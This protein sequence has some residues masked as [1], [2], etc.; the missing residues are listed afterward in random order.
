MATE[1]AMRLLR[2]CGGE[3]LATILVEVVE[4][5]LGRGCDQV[6]TCRK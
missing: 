6:I 4:E 1:S 3:V 2:V 5:V